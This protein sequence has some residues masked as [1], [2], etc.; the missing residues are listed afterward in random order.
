MTNA[1]RFLQT[2]P[3]FTLAAC[4]GD[5]DFAPALETYAAIAEATY[6][7]SR[8]T[9]LAL[10]SANDA[11]VA[12][13]SETTL[14]AAR[15]AWLASREPYGQSEV[16]RFYGG[17]IEQ[18]DPEI[19]GA[20]NAWPIDESVIDYVRDPGSGTIQPT[21][22]VNDP[23][24][25]IDEATLRAENG[26][27]AEEAVTTGYHPIEFLLWGQDDPE[28]DGTGARPATDY[29]DGM[30]ENAA[31]RATYL[32]VASDLLVADLDRVL[33]L[34][35]GEYRASFTSGGRASI[36]DVLHAMA[37][38]SEAELGGERIGVALETGDQEDEHSCFSDNTH[39]DAATNAMGIRNVYLGQYRRVD[40]TMVTGP[41]LSDLVRERDAAL[42]TRLRSELDASV[43]AAQAIV[44][45]FDREIVRTEGRARLQALIAALRAQSQSI[46]EAGRLFGIEI[47]LG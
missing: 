28:Q 43:A 31:R 19:E 21:G 34:W 36:R 8:T 6:E 45:P 2:F 40:G 7:D 47:T 11:L 26:A 30:G 13:P 16:L 32:G 29:V 18:G 44:P 3:L 38:L 20:L 25:T 39:R 35:R 24:R 46:Q 4:G 22:L 1:R 10:Q 37:F 5:P 41:S 42:D 14:E 27:A 15:A 33:A 12:T 9:A 17:P 23:A